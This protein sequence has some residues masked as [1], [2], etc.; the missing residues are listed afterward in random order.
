[1]SKATNQNIVR[2][3][4]GRVN[5]PVAASTHLYEGC[6]SFID[7][8]GR[9]VATINSGANKL[10]GMNATEVDNSTGGAGAKNVEL[11]RDV[12]QLE[13]SGFT[14]ADVEKACFVS[15][16]FTATLTAVGNVYAGPIVKVIDSTK[17]M[18]DLS[19]GAREPKRSAYTQ[20]FATADKTHANPTATALTDNTAGT[21]TTT[22]EAMA[23]PTDTPATADILRDDLVANLL[24]AIRNNFADLAASNN[25]LIVDLADAKA[26]INS[27]IDDLQA[28]GLVG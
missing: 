24:P 26:L 8:D 21:A 10:G 25:A 20:T 7:S 3:P 27:L 2:E 19:K 23:N 17:V 13:G 22:L 18:V 6:L 11:I 28:L 14:A 9:A 4:A 15:D 12:V 1:M 16:N 5:R